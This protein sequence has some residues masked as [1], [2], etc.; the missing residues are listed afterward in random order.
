MTDV[1]DR[2]TAA[3]PVRD[4]APA[5]P[6]ERLKRR[7]V[8]APAHRRRSRRLVPALVAGAAIAAAG[9]ALVTGSG[10][11][12][13]DLAER[14]YAQTAPGDAVIHFVVRSSF[15]FGPDG[16]EH[17][18]VS[19]AERWVHGRRSRT[20]VTLTENG[21]SMT[22]D[23]VLGADGVLRSHLP[24]GEVQLVRPRDGAEAREILDEAQDDAVALFRREYEAGALEDAGSTTFHGHEARMYVREQTRT[25]PARPNDPVAPRWQRTRREF[26]LDA[27]TAEPLGLREQSVNATGRLEQEM[28]IERFERL[29]ATPENLRHL[30]R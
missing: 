10:G 8:S 15:G 24:E 20:L 16:R 30:E 27:Q 17:Y 6:D 9:L 28:V 13:V 26:F 18:T 1:L 2:L 19:R 3:D 22:Y 23:Q 14:A 7:I 21:R 4:D 25:F 12:G 11:S 5:P 29:P